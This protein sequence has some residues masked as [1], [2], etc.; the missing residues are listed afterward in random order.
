MDARTLYLTFVLNLQ[1]GAS[2]RGKWVKEHDIFAACGDNVRYQIRRIP[3]CPKLIKIGSN[4]N[5]STG[6]TLVVHDAIHLVYNCLP[7]KTMRLSEY[8]NPIEIGDNVFLGSNVSVMGGVRIGSNI[9]VAA[10]AV[11]TKDLEDGGIYGGVPAKR[12]GNI[13]DFWKKRETEYYPSIKNNMR[14][15]EKEIADCWK[16]F[17]ESR[18]E[19]K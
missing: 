3:L 7:G 11:V 12:I 6:V 8:A 5:L 17:Y 2:Q 19:H 4:V 15:T 18:G 13:E 10:G 14:L 16:Y 1:R 9:I